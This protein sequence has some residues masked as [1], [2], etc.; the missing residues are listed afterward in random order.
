MEL[1][2]VEHL[3]GLEGGKINKMNPPYTITC[4]AQYHLELLPFSVIIIRRNVSLESFAVTN[5]SAKTAKVFHFERI[6]EFHRVI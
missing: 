1:C 6:E 5:Q 2:T 3:F 4:K